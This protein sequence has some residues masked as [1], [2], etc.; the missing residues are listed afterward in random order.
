L[1]TGLYRIDLLNG[2]ATLLRQYQGTLSGLTVS[3]VPEPG[4]TPAAQATVR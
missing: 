1:S 2:Q 3:A 4:A